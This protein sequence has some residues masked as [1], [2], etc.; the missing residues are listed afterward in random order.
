MGRQDLGVG[1]SWLQFY[2][3]KGSLEVERG[4]FGED[5]DC[6]CPQHACDLGNSLVEKVSQVVYA[7]HMD[8][9]QLVGVAGQE[10]D[11]GHL[12]KAGNLLDKGLEWDLLI[13]GN[14]D[15]GLDGKAQSLL[16]DHDG[17]ATDDTRLLQALDPVANGGHWTVQALGQ[18]RHGLARV[19]F[20]FVQDGSIQSIQ[21]SHLAV[22][23]WVSR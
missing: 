6:I 9:D 21:L 12:R 5:N 2:L 16:V 10:L 17:V 3:P 18:G 15:N 8:G 22:P 13:P 7:A 19:F 23:L 1:G 4:D 11:A 20:Q 14:V